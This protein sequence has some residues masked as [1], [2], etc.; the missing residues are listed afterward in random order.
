MRWEEEFDKDVRELEQELKRSID[1]LRSKLNFL[2]QEELIRRMEARAERSRRE[3]RL[4][5]ALASVLVMLFVA[6]SLLSIWKRYEHPKYLSF[7]YV[8]S[9]HLIDDDLSLKEEPT[10]LD[11]YLGDPT[12]YFLSD[13]DI[14]EVSEG[15]VRIYI[16]ESGY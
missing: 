6:I 15:K 13:K 16:D 9:E 12:I 3:Y 2:S 14:R 8:I 10:A 5:F 4:S 7:N 11:L 1:S